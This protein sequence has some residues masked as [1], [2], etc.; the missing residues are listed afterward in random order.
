M[1]QKKISTPKIILSPTASQIL[2]KNN[3]TTTIKTL[4][5]EPLRVIIEGDI[6]QP[7]PQPKPQSI[8]L[9]VK[10]EQKQKQKNSEIIGSKIVVDV[11]ELG[12]DEEVDESNE[13]EEND[14]NVE[15]E[16]TK[17]NE[18][19]KNTKP[20]RKPRTKKVYPPSDDMFDELIKS[21]C[22]LREITR[23]AITLARETQKASRKEIKELNGSIK[24]EKSDKPT[25]KPRGFALPSPISDEMVDYLLNE[26]NITQ[27]SRKVGDQVVGVVKIEHGC[28]LARNELTAALCTH[29]RTSLM[30]KNE[31]DKRDIHLD[32]K[33]SRLFRIDTNKFVENG[34]RLSS[35]GEP[36]ITYFDLQKYLPVHCG[37]QATGH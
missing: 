23:K 11:N 25:R 36:I 10:S 22:D 30:R 20:K 29:F 9:S 5:P 16:K 6:I 1:T 14:M 21:L 33:T 37:K 18:N 8:D 24:K 12:E 19:A 4:I 7:Q 2:D 32:G 35:T 26:A 3:N 15:E 34:G 28:Q 27:I 31:L 13:V 17:I